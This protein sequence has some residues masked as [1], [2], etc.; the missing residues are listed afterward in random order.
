[1]ACGLGQRGP[2]WFCRAEGDCCSVCGE[3]LCTAHE[4]FDPKSLA[5]RAVGAVAKAVGVRPRIFTGA[6]TPFNDP[7]KLQR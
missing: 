3:F 1:M 4:N 2:C 7:R 6:P 5:L